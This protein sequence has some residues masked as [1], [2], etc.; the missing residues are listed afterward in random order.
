MLGRKT[1]E[2]GKLSPLSVV[3]TPGAFTGLMGTAGC[4]LNG[5]AFETGFALSLMPLEGSFKSL[6]YQ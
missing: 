6:V 3:P 5:V 4:I 2:S 1:T